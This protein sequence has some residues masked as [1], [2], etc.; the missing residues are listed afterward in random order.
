MI[1]ISYDDLTKND[2]KIT[3]LKRP[4]NIKYNK[5]PFDDFEKNQKEY[6][7]MIYQLYNKEKENKELSFRDKELKFQD[8]LNYYLDTLQYHRKFMNESEKL[9][10]TFLYYRISSLNLKN[11]GIFV[12]CKNKIKLK[13]WDD[14][15]IFVNM[16]KIKKKRKKYKYLFSTTYAPNLFK[17]LTGKYVCD[18]EEI[19]Y[20]YALMNLY[21]YFEFLEEGGDAHFKI[22]STC[23]SQTIELIYLLSSLFQYVFTSDGQTYYCY[24]FLPNYRVTKKDII[25]CIRKPFFKIEP[26]PGLKNFLKTIEKITISSS[27]YYSQSVYFKMIYCSYLNLDIIFAY[28]PLEFFKFKNI[29]QYQILFLTDILKNQPIDYFYK[30]KQFTFFQNYMETLSQLF[31]KNTFKH[32]LELDIGWGIQSIFFLQQKSIQ[33]YYLIDSFEQIFYQNQ[34]Y[35]FL[36]NHLTTQQKKKLKFSSENYLFLLSKLFESYHDTF[37]DFI[38]LNNF[39]TEDDFLMKF[40][41]CDKLIQPKGILMINNTSYYLYIHFIPLILQQYKNYSIYQHNPNSILL[42]KI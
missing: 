32:I 34:H 35:H 17:K 10:K 16:E 5:K 21:I 37:F 26:K 12:E 25:Q 13:K 1:R 2:V 29:I 30:T 15:S 38:L 8:S 4:S 41:Y 14:I 18:K 40:F 20:K 31:K 27:F 23:H 6:R 11:P 36:Q 19:E 39:T 24:F 9:S 22:F 28:S 42:Q 33:K 3:Y 7:N